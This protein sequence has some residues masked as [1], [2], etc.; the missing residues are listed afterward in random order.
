MVTLSVIL[1]IKVIA[2]MDVSE[3]MTDIPPKSYPFQGYTWLNAMSCPQNFD[4]NEWK[5]PMV[6]INQKI[7]TGKKRKLMKGG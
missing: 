1:L 2:F 6:S 7:K 4:C 5:C 3:E